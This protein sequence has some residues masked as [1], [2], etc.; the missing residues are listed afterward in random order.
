[1]LQAAVLMGCADGAGT[2]AVHTDAV[3]GDLLR[4]AFHQQH[5][6]ALT[7]GVV[8]VTGPRDDFV[9]AAHV[10]DFTR[11]ARDG[12]HDAATLKLTDGFAGAQ[13]LPGEVD[14]DHL[15]PLGERHVGE[16]R[17]LLQGRRC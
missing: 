3:R 2:D 1:M 13:E 6:A 4:D 5:N 15:L 11:R 16:G 12:R 10:D 9:H 17:I 7:G 8:G 14:V